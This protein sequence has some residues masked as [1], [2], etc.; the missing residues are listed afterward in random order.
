VVTLAGLIAVT[1]NRTDVAQA[2]ASALDVRIVADGAERHVR[3]SQ[4]TVGATLREAGIDIGPADLIS[5]KPSAKV[6]RNTT[7]RVV[8]VVDRVVLE[9]EPIAFKTRRQPTS[10]LRVGISS[11]VSE[12]ER[13]LKHLYY[14]VRYVDGKEKKRSLIRTE[15]ASKPKDKVIMAGALG[16]GMSR[17]VF[18]SRRMLTMHATAYDPG[19]R[20]CGPR[21]TGRTCTGM[22]AGYGVVAVDPRVIP[23]GTRLY[24]EGYGFAVAG[25]RG[26]AIKGQ[27]IDLGFDTYS[28]AKRFGRQHVNVHIVE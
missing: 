14:Q 7:I 23:L 21:A 17:G 16:A 1:A 9:E 18:T 28:R 12:G 22:K 25:D 2:Q 24:V 13:G 6:S 26:R 27:R 19:P 20:S 15:V 5:P 3:T 4:T 8:R 11:V 10:K